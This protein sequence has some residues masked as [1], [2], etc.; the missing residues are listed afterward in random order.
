[1]TTAR[2]ALALVASA[3]TGVAIAAAATPQGSTG[4]AAA[5]L[6]GVPATQPGGAV[7]RGPAMRAAA[8]GRAAAVPL[9]AGGTFD[10]IQWERGG[11]ASASDI[12]GVLEYN[13]ACQWLRAWRDGRNA[14]LA[15]DVLAEVPRWPALRDTE[16]GE[17]LARV[18]AEAAEGGGETATAMLADCDASHE[19]EVEYATGLGLT[20][21]R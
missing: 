14:A 8:T 4:A 1:M 2:I 6:T 11:E 3:L 16:S 21:G 19:R 10:G 7:F 5:A 13:A 17:F 20:A 12:E 15:L 9:P 18:A